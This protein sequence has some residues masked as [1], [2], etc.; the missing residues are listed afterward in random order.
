[1]IGEGLDSAVPTEESQLKI[2]RFM[3]KER[4]I[5]HPIAREETKGN[6]KQGGVTEGGQLI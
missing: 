6:S 2:E 5:R 4:Y 1:M 3:T